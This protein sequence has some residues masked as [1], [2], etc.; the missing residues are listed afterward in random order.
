MCLDKDILHKGNKIYSPEYC[1]FVTQD[2][3]KL[4]IKCNKSRGK[5]PIGVGYDKKLKK[6]YS[7]CAKMANI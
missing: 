5:H 1:I 2:I 4:F 6:Y 7:G 3:N